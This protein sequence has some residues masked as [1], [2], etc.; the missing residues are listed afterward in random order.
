MFPPVK[1]I[2]MSRDRRR[3]ISYVVGIKRL[4]SSLGHATLRRFGVDCHKVTLGTCHFMRLV[5]LCEHLGTT[6]VFDIGANEGQFARGLLSAGY[7]G[8]V[9]SVEPS[10]DAHGSLAIA[11][12]G[13]SRWIVASR[14]AVGA[15]VGTA[16]LH[17]AGNSV[18]SSLRPMLD[19]HQS[20]APNSVYVRSE[21][22]DIVTMEDLFSQH[23][24]ATDRG[25]F[26]KA[27]VQGH[28]S[29]VLRGA[30]KVLPR[31]DAI[32]LE[33]SL[34]PL[35]EGESMFID[36]VLAMKSRGYALWQVE[37]GFMDNRTGRLLQVDGTFV[38]ESRC[39]EM[40]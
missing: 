12:R 7:C 11:A 27:D 16:E 31:I 30:A 5:R 28:E 9:I 40:E 34:V 3:R 21:T 35:Y 8:R 13:H 15:T 25:I 6:V 26:M 19:T 22:C 20:A 37:P 39:S 18:S 29:E 24:Q 14:C 1:R 4:I 36:Q 33:M 38:R 2:G 10:K 32:Q 23:V 17:I